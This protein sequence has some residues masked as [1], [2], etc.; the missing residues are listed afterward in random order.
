MRFS[1]AQTYFVPSDLLSRITDAAGVTNMV[2]GKGRRSSI[3]RDVRIL[4]TIGMMI[5]T[6]VM[7]IYLFALLQWELMA[8]VPAMPCA[9]VRS[10]LYASLTDPT[11][12]QISREH[13]GSRWL[14]GLHYK[15]TQSQNE[16]HRPCVCGSPCKFFGDTVARCKLFSGP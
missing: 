3:D 1:Q 6:K 10:A 5:L 7:N 4:H 8:D 15:S 13:T 2:L 14:P 9:S 12:F 11:M 16:E